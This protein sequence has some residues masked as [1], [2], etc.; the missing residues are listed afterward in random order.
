MHLVQKITWKTQIRQRQTRRASTARACLFH[1]L[2]PIFMAR[3]LVLALCLCVVVL[4]GCGQAAVTNSAQNIQQQSQ[5]TDLTYVAIGASDTF[6]IGAS[7]PYQE[8]WPSDLTTL[9]GEQHI[10]LIN[11]G[12]P[13]M[14]VHV[15][16][17]AELPIALSAHP[18]LI[19]IWLAV[20][21][22]ATNVPS[23][24]YSHDLN[25]MLSRLQAVAPRARIEVGNV[26]DL[27]S[28][29]F[30]HSYDQVTL[31]QQ[32][33]AYNMAIA[34][35]VQR[36][37]VILVDL[38]GQGYNLQ[39]FPEYISSDGLHPSTAGYFQLAELFYDALQKK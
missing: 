27:T 33:T 32:I 6:G 39:E 14:T 9:L 2:R 10:H 15:A 35:V 17:T 29:P 38:S 3:R 28:V 31:R 26:P 24:S 36:H 23:G 13:G 20:N 5:T 4:G 18:G 11:L 16:L 30:F 1:F 12:V 7:D 19:T 21:D 25:T 8:N 37:H 34:S 22:L